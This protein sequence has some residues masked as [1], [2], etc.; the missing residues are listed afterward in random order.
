MVLTFNVISALAGIELTNIIR[1]RIWNKESTAWYLKACRSSWTHI[2]IWRGGY[3]CV[4]LK[5]QAHVFISQCVDAEAT[6]FSQNMTSTIVESTN[7]KA[8]V[9]T[10]KEKIKK[11]HTHFTLFSSSPFLLHIL[12]LKLFHKIWRE[13]KKVVLNSITG[14]NP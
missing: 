2:P 14:L 4:Q 11:S 10:N 12:H 13:K 3:E 8:K 6:L 7:K 1:G 9:K 5:S